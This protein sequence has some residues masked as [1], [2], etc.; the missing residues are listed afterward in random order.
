MPARISATQ[1]P[2]Y[3]LH[4]PSGREV[5]TFGRR[6]DYLGAHNT[7]DVPAG[8]P[9]LMPSSRESLENTALLSLVSWTS[10]AHGP[11][12][13]RADGSDDV[14]NCRN[15]VTVAPVRFMTCQ[16]TPANLTIASRIT[17]VSD[18]QAA[19]RRVRSASAAT[20]LDSARCCVRRR[21]FPEKLGAFRMPQGSLVRRKPSAR[22][23]GSRVC[24]PRR[25]GRPDGFHFAF[26]GG[27]LER[28]DRA[29]DLPSQS[30]LI[31]MFRQRHLAPLA[32]SCVPPWTCSAIG[33]SRPSCLRIS[34]LL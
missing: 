6:N 26:V 19:A 30:G 27:I 28:R 7:R 17:T 13:D 18:G 25:A 23:K 12:I 20:A 2:R 4:R 16:R 33:P 22:V 11:L 14:A 34:S 5:V 10:S 29:A 32:H 24:P 1:S 15:C 9:S 3:W 31:R 8:V 21:V